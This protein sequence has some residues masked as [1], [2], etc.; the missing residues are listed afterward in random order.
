MTKSGVR[1]GSQPIVAVIDPGV[2]RK[3][4]FV[5][6]LWATLA[7]ITL[8]V[9]TRTLVTL[10]RTAVRFWPATTVLTAVALLWRGYG[11]PGL[12]TG[13]LL[14][15]VVVWAV[16]AWLRLLTPARYARMVTEPVRGHW[17]WHR[18]YRR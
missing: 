1:S 10:A 8:R 3:E 4:R 15:A 16:L 13:G 12:L 11:V 18:V 7:G 2:I 17:R 6:P 14:A 9:L 5:L